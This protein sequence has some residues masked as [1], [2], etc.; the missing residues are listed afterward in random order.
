VRFHREAAAIYAGPE[1]GD[2]RMEGLVRS[3]VAGLLRKLGRLDEARREIDRAIV[4]KQPFS[5]TA[6]PWK[7]FE[8]LSNI[9]R[10]A[11]R[12]EAALDARR[13]AFNAFLAY[14]RDGGENQ[15]GRMTPNLCT[16]LLA[17]VR[18]GQTR[19]FGQALIELAARPNNPA[20]LTPVLAALRTILAGSRDSALADDPAL[21]YDDAAEILLLLEQLKAAGL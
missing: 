11:G 18:G 8:I 17:A 13:R 5:H 4:C 2:L 7:T 20:Y 12:A 19:A 6:E 9:E 14:R 10:G 1:V 16:G 3:N 21:E 15:F